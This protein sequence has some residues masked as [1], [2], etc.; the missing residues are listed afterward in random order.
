MEVHSGA[1]EGIEIEID[2]GVPVGSG[3]GSSAASAAAA[4]WGAA[5]LLAAGGTPARARRHRIWMQ[6]NPHGQNA[7][8]HVKCTTAKRNGRN[9]P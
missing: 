5:R 4:A 3:L 2:K 8:L 1:T 9:G 7:R 6:S